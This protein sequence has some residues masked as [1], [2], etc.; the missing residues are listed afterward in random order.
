M[1]EALP[2]LRAEF[3]LRWV[4]GAVSIVLISRILGFAPLICLRYYLD[5]WATKFSWSGLESLY[6][7]P[8]QL[9]RT[10]QNYIHNS[11][12][13]LDHVYVTS[14]HKLSFMLLILPCLH[15]SAQQAAPALPVTQQTVEVTTTI[16]PI[17]LSETLRAVETIDTR[18]PLFLNNFTDYLR[19]DPSLNLQA[20]GANGVQAD[21]SIRGTTF[22]QSL[23]LLNGLRIND[24]ETGHLNLDIPAPLDAISRIEVLHGSGSTFYGSDAI[25][26]A[27]N[28]I[29]QQPR[30]MAFIGK[31]GAGNYGSLEQHLRAD[32]ATKPISEQ[33]TASRD[34][35]DGFIPDRN[36]SSNAPRSRCASRSAARNSLDGSRAAKRSARSSTARA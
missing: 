15:S 6:G 8:C 24:T 22:E 11:R 2:F 13:N 26:G 25:G 31:L 28:L 9:L 14:L 29:T 12:Y 21:L 20:R 30:A 5:H 34:T 10:R 1:K 27:V 36:Y 3:R 18:Q 32:Y 19:Q 33:I 7:L 35:S 4:V 17:P 16:P 23:V